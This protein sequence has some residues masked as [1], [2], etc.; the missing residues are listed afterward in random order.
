MKA[1]IPA[2]G[3]GTR[4]LPATKS[5][6]KE[7]L[8]VLDKPA[9]QYVVEEAAASGL[10]DVLMITGRNKR[11]IE[12]HFDEAPELED[13]LRRTG[14][15]EALAQVA[16]ISKLARIFYVRQAQPLGL[17]H[18]VLQAAP[19]TGD[20]PFAVLL[21]DDIVVGP[22]PATAELIDVFRAKNASVLAV[23][24][25]PREQVS[26]Y[27]IVKTE[28]LGGGL[29]RI[30]DIVEKPSAEAAPSNLASIGRY[31]FTPGL[32]KELEGVKPGVGGEIQLT[33]A[34]RAL[35]RKEDVYALELTSKR[36]DVGSLRGWLEATVGLA[37]GRAELT[38][39][40]ESAL[41]R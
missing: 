3:F 27:G 24:P 6:P 17:G 12:D 19:H 9:I 1:V 36:Y 39:A 32:M 23:Q 14:R 35:L 37:A 7:M 33:D 25:V 29:H 31:V 21:G 30:V 40:I 5:M 2:G 10:R 11:A 16:A 34:V 13:F 41:K 8:P 4:L 22:R 15:H 18:A 28:P 20:H 26:K 38:S